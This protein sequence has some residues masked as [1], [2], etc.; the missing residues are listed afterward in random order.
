MEQK[1]QV[2]MA[3][4]S[5]PEKAES[6][7][8][9][10]LRYQNQTVMDAVKNISTPDRIVEFR[11]QLHQKIYPIYA[12]EH[13]PKHYFDF[14]AN[15]YQPTKY[16]AGA[17]HDTFRFNIMMIWVMTGLLFLTLYFDLLHSLIIRVENW[18]KYG[19]RRVRD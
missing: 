8:R 16:F 12:D 17:N 3:L 5:T 15:L 19:K 4:M 6:F 10:K 1:E 13:K 18:L 11:G 14:S 9:S 7:E 2:V